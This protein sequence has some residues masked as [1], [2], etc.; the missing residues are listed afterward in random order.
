MDTSN[1]PSQDSS[2]DDDE[3]SIK[4]QDKRH[5]ELRDTWC[6]REEKS[7]H[8]YVF[9]RSM[10]S[11]AQKASKAIQQL[12]RG[13]WKSGHSLYQPGMPFH[14]GLTHVRKHPL[15]E[16]LSSMPKGCLLHAHMEAMIEPQWI[17]RQALELPGYYI[18]ANKALDPHNRGV[19]AEFDFVYAP[20][21]TVSVKENIWSPSYTPGALVALPDAAG[22]HPLEGQGFLNWASAQMAIGPDDLKHTGGNLEIWQKFLHCYMVVNGVFW[23]EPVLRRFV[24]ELF[25]RLHQNGIRYVELRVAFLAPF[26]R[27]GQDGPDADYHYFLTCFR[28]EMDNYMSSTEAASFWGARVIWSTLRDADDA[29]IRRAMEACIA[30]KQ[31]FPSL[32]SGFDFVGN[33]DTGR[34]L[35]DLR[36]LC[37]WFQNRTKSLGLEIPFFF[38]VGETLGDGSAA[39][40][41][42]SDAILLGSRRLGHAFS[43]YKHPVLI[44]EVKAHSI[45]VE[46]CPVSHEVLGLTPSM[47]SHPLPVFLAN[48]VPVSLNN[49]DPGM[50]GY[51]ESGL[52]HD[53]FQTLICFDKVGLEGL[54]TMAE[55]SIRWAAFQDESYDEWI[56]GVHSDLQNG[57]QSLKAERLQSWR[58]EFERWCY[59][60]VEN[61]DY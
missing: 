12:V 20:K 6:L 18:K 47:L 53:F 23:T 11:T 39:D 45:L 59:R 30:A 7:R 24:P 36:L 8:D 46:M 50:L 22:T 52:T 26:Q 42:L 60:L 37:Y 28:E 35:R 43:L 41:N 33:E 25:R 57:R 19:P 13:T 3:A 4:S 38:H 54:G 31:S 44:E 27:T 48:N 9:K 58:E 34:S 17:I 55:N 61:H 10:S 51:G 16:I 40:E 32:I 2:R 56:C 29:T 21:R 1:P 15:W 14:R 49:D 5:D